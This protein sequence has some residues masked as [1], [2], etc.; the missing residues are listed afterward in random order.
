MLIMLTIGIIFYRFNLVFVNF[1][2]LV[3]VKFLKKKL[4]LKR[5][6]KFEAELNAMNWLIKW[7]D[8]STTMSSNERKTSLGKKKKA[9]LNQN[10]YLNENKQQLADDSVSLTSIDLR[11]SNSKAVVYKVAFF[12][13]VGKTLFAINNYS[14]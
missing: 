1:V 7:Q 11:C 10:Y 13:V 9:L 4:F 8:V 2:S 5:K 12:V 6:T 3:E 14:I